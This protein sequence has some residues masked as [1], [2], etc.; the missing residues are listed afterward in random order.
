MRARLK[1]VRYAKVITTSWMAARLFISG[2][3]H[4]IFILSWC[5][6]AK[7]VQRAFQRSSSKKTWRGCQLRC[8]GKE[9]GMEKPTDRRCQFRQCEG[10]CHKPF[11]WRGRRFQI[12]HE[13]SWWRTYQYCGLCNPKVLH[14]RLN[15]PN[16]ICMK[17]RNSVKACGFPSAAIQDF[18][19]M[20]ERTWSGEIDGL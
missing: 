14:V 19:D 7:K 4:P 20:S 8:F 11:G 3:V 6:Q 12:R 16:N 10:A 2:A 5:V 18:A 15:S 13:R 17:E 9:N 1:P